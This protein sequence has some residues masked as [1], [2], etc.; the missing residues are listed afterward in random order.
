MNKPFFKICVFV[1]I[2]FLMWSVNGCAKDS[3]MQV[4][5]SIKA[6]NIDKIYD[7]SSQYEIDPKWKNSDGKTLIELAQGTKNS[8]IIYAVMYGLNKS[9]FK[10]IN[11]EWVIKTSANKENDDFMILKVNFDEKK[12]FAYWSC[13][14]VAKNKDDARIANEM[15]GK[16]LKLNIDNGVLVGYRDLGMIGQTNIKIFKENKIWYLIQKFS[17]SKSIDKSELIRY[18]GKK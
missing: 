15:F 4:S 2:C 6:K 9:L 8:D 3:N 10:E 16:E 11:G 14:K 12:H 13:R 7:I 5:D 18:N 17:N 1:S